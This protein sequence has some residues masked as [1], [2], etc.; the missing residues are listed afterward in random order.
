MFLRNEL[1]RRG[2]FRLL[3]IPFQ[4]KKGVQSLVEG[5]FVRGA[6]ADEQGEALFVDGNFI[7]EAGEGEAVILKA[8]GALE[9]PIGLGELV[10]E[11][12]FGGIGG[13]VFAEQGSA[14][15]FEGGGVLA[16]DEGDGGGEAV[17]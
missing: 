10:D 12:L 14:E 11:D 13:L 17:L 7:V 2:E 15:G 8:E 3:A 4:A 9:E 6:V 1:A 16:G 5:A